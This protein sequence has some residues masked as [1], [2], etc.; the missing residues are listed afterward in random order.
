MFRRK[1]YGHLLD[2][3]NRAAGRSALLL[4]GARR[5]GKS[6]LAREFGE[7]EYRSH[8]VIDF[9]VVDDS[10][11]AAFLENRQ[12]L[13]A[14]FMFLSAYA[15][16]TLHERETLLVFDEIQRFPKAREFVKHIVADGRYDL[17]ET[18]SLISI[19]KNVK[20]IVIPSEEDGLA[21]NPLDFE[22]FLWALGEEPLA[23]GIRSAFGD[24]SPLPNALHRKAMRLFREYML[25]GGMPQAVTE[26]KGSHDLARVD[27]VKRR[28]LRLYRDD[29]VKFADSEKG[30]VQA[31][32]D[33]IPG[34]LSKHEKKFTLSAID[35]NARSRSY[36]GVFFWLGDARIANICLNAT[37]PSVGLSMSQDNSTLKCYMADTGLLVASAFASRSSTPSEVYRDI[38]LDKL[39]IN[40]G[41]LVENVVAQQLVA[42]GHRLFFYSRYSDMAKERMEIDFL[43]AGEYENAAMRLRV[44]PVEVKS[45]S[46]YGT[47][48]L[49]KLKSRFTKRIGTQYVVHPRQ[50]AV[51]GDR[52]FIPLYMSFCL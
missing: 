37:D 48:S 33:A 41:M 42:A 36:E 51:D 12:S 1:A 15:G 27:Q 7:R 39:A 19:K 52:V 16:T 26:Y 14:F 18:G 17:L 31:V 22:E 50:L 43:I 44:C 34:Q 25:V 6:T 24:K 11:T 28:I 8:I 45:R 35:K 20:D 4:E 13:D 29:I 2:W 9:S 10:F 49:N 32:F 5:V 3:K 40:E 23:N 30:K 46:R 38:L 21:L 47:S